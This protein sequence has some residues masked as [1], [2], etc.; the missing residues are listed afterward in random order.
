MLLTALGMLLFI[1]GSIIFAEIVSFF[2]TAI[3]F[4][5]IGIIKTSDLFIATVEGIESIAWRLKEWLE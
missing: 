1:V 3:L 4:V 5:I 2:I